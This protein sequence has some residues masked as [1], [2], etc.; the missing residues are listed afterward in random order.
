MDFRSRSLRIWIAAAILA[1]TT[2]VMSAAQLA[3]SRQR[4]IDSG[5]ELARALSNAAAQRV[6]SSM[7]LLDQ[8][9]QEA[10]SR[11]PTDGPAPTGILEPL[12]P[13]LA[14]TKE[15]RALSLI[16]ADGIMRQVVH[17]Q[18]QTLSLPADISDRQHY[19]Y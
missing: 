13:K 11:I 4:H 5:Q 17:R 12:R 6:M 8:L 7:Q 16:D 18:Q 3:Y 10:V 14:T 1:L 15:I 19:Q 2:S 9:L